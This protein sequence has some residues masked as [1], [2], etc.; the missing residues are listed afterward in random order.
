MNTHNLHNHKIY[1]HRYLTTQNRG[2]I[3]EKDNINTTLLGI[4]DELAK[5]SNYKDPTIFDVDA[6]LK[7]E[8]LYERK[9]F[10]P[11]AENIMQ[12]LSMGIR[13]HALII[14]PRGS[15][16]TAIVKYILKEAVKIINNFEYIYINCRDLDNSYKI[17]KG[18]IRQ[19]KKVPKDEVLYTFIDALNATDKKKILILDEVDLI[20]DDDIIYNITRRDDLNKVHMILIT[21]TPKFYDNLSSDVKS[22]LKKDTFYFDTYDYQHIK[23]I[24]QK[25]ATYGFHN[26]DPSILYEIAVSNVKHAGSDVRV[27]IR[28]LEQ[29]FKHMDHTQ[30]EPSDKKQIEYAR[31]KISGMM[32]TEYQRMKEGVI[33]NLS[34]L[35]LSILY[36]ILKFGQSNKAYASFSNKSYTV[37]SKSNF[38]RHVDELAYMD[39]FSIQRTRTGRSTVLHFVE[40]VGEQNQKLINEL[41]KYKGVLIGDSNG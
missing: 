2:G 16:K 40:N 3:L 27:G 11:V 36:F 30:I 25:R 12:F 34:E 6:D 5:F 24:L 7:P 39:L 1:K 26:Y 20:R 38:F 8:L 10:K 32:E 14:G 9:Q 13:Q 35:K 37:V 31:K 22:S 33:R 17:M 15:G 29:I 23:E 41:V 21:K 18:V 4:K 28:V 19:K